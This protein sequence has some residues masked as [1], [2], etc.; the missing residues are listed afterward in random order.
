MKNRDIANDTEAVIRRAI[1]LV[2]TYDTIGKREFE[3]VHAL[4]LQSVQKNT[5]IRMEDIA[6][7]TD[8]VLQDLPNE[9]GQLDAASKSWDALIG[10]LYAKY[11]KEL[12]I[13]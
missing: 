12:G 10:Y 9:Y 6:Q 11:L 7:K 5:G 2:R 13:L 8:K 4:I 1:K 3:A